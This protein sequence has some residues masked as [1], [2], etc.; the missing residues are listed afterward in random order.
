MERSLLN[1]PEHKQKSLSPR[2]FIYRCVVDPKLAQKLPDQFCSN[3][4]KTFTLGYNRCMRIILKY[5]ENQELFWPNNSGFISQKTG[6]WRWNFFLGRRCKTT[7]SRSKFRHEY[8]LNQFQGMKLDRTRKQ[9]MFWIPFLSPL[10]YHQLFFVFDDV[11]NTKKYNFW[12]HLFHNCIFINA[13]M[14]TVLL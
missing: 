7:T 9:G 2:I 3:W 6:L 11:S 13:N 12:Y 10:D 4:H 5:S 1:V 14:T 8:N